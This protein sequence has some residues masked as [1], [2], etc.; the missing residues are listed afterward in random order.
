MQRQEDEPYHVTIEIENRGCKGLKTLR[1]SGIQQYTLSDVR[2]LPEGLTRH[3]IKVPSREIRQM[4]KDTFSKIRSNRQ[5][6]G[7]SSAWFDSDG[8]DVCRAILS[9]NSFLISGRHV[10]G[11]TIIYSFV[12]PNFDA[13]KSIISTLE[14]EGLKPKILEVAKFKPKGKIL[15]EKQERALWLGL[16]MGFFEYPRK[17]NMLE[18]AH[19]L[20]IGLSTLSEITRRGIRRLLEDHFEM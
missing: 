20:E 8:C 17:V 14:A 9:H 12:T 16:K 2:S 10:E 13:F 6:E 19:R 7:G 11:N 18:L 5:I 4:P 3:L 1:N 15:T